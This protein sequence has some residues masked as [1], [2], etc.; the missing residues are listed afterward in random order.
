MPDP[1]II[2][3]T[4]VKNEEWILEEFLNITSLFADYIIV[5][6]QNS[7]DKSRA[8][9]SKFSKVHL[10]DNNNN[11]YN[12]AERQNLLIETA[13]ILFPDNKR[14]LLALDADELFSANSLKCNRIWERIMSLDLGTTLYFE[15]PDILPGVTKCV[16]YQDNYFAIGYIDDRSKTFS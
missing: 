7:T 12:E 6:D 9:C 14:V 11:E 4:P 15:K 8:I 3:L 2:V 10:I 16:R 13:R 1:K 5:A